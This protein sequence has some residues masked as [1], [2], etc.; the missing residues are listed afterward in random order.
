MSIEMKALLK[1]KEGLTDHSDW[2]SSWAGDDCCKWRGVGCNNTTGRVG[3]LN[4]R[5]SYS[6]GTIH[7][8][9]AYMSSPCHI[10]L[11]LSEKEDP[12]KKELRSPE[13]KNR[14]SHTQRRNFLRCVV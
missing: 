11:T 8:L 5:N 12:V 9:E 10:E 14:S 7:A 6:D 3:S 2:L 4:L 1:L 13:I